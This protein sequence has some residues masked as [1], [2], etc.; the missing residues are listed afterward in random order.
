MNFDPSAAAAPDSGVFGLNHTAEDSAVV[1]IPAPYD[2]TVSYGVGTSLGPAAILEAS[3][4]VDLEDPQFGEFWRAGIHMEDADLRFEALN[5]EARGHV[6]RARDGAADAA[7][8]A[9]EC[10]SIVRTMIRNRA[11]A[12]FSAGR[13][14][15]LV[16]GEHAVSFGIMEAAAETGPVGVL[17]IDA[18]DDLRSAYE[19][20]TWSHASVMRN[21]VDRLPNIKRVVS[22]GV[23][24]SC[25]EEREKKSQLGSRWVAYDDL[26][27][28]RRVE[29]GEPF[30]VIAQ[31]AVAQLPERVH[32]TLDI[33][34]LD[35]SL[36]PGTGTPVPGGLS[37][38]R[39]LVLIEALRESGK[40]VTSFDVVEV[41]PVGDHE[42][43]ANVG[44]RVVFKLCGL[45]VAS[46]S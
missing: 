26:T 34:G 40:T 31:E 35:P 16:G 46:R 7:A 19:G 11:R 5:H 17:H 14:P 13:I 3:K 2:A 36:C 25:A 9:D 30:A 45:A 43:D 38:H 21:V 41:S 32:V 15:G 33:D 28:A 10:G 4:Q 20:F 39:L 24:D 18:H 6:A 29:G 44:A 27:L 23:R 1:L 8:L 22:V 42:W 37:F 12:A